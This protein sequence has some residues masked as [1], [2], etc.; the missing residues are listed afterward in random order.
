METV[1]PPIVELA[2]HERHDGAIVAA[3]MG[4]G[5]V[6]YLD[7]P[8]LSLRFLPSFSEKIEKI[9]VKAPHGRMPSVET[10]LGTMSTLDPVMS[11]YWAPT[12]I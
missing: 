5:R 9:H 1:E 8:N 2:V 11:E 4:R 10:I 3:D 12:Y 6:R 7:S